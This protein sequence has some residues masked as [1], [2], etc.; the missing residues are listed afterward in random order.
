MSAME[1]PMQRQ[2]LYLDGVQEME[3][4]SGEEPGLLC[5]LGGTLRSWMTVEAS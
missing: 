2:N 4:P 3:R 1:A 5:F